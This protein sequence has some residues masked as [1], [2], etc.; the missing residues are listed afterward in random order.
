MDTQRSDKSD[1]A[2]KPLDAAVQ[3]ALVEAREEMLV[4]LQ[5]RLRNRDDAE[6]VLQRLSLRALE[7]ASQL[8][9]I[10][11]VR[12][13]LGRILATTLVDH[14]RNLSRRRRR[15]TPVDD[16]E[17]ESEPVDAELDAAVCNCLYRLLP[18]LK[19]EYSDI[20]WRADILGEPR[21]R[22]AASLGTSLN[23]VTV[24]LHRG[25]QALRKRLEEMCRTCP[26]H[27][28][29]DCHCEKAEKIRKAHE[30]VSR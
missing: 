26:I 21:D 23:N 8:R 15:E 9:D 6:E 4:F 19:P 27:G 17:I 11:T 1:D 20:V 10:R 13:W 2:A 25:R 28:F 29:L 22:L 24:R 18:T 30:D 12:G 16:A 3:R 7:R 5:R 14:Q